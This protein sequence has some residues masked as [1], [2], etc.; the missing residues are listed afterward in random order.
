MKPIA[1]L[2]SGEQVIFT[3]YTLQA[4]ANFINSLIYRSFNRFMKIHRWNQ[5][6]GPKVTR[7]RS[8]E[9]YKLKPFN[10]EKRYKR[11]YMPS[12]FGTA[13]RFEYFDEKYV[14]TEG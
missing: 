11:R 3:G 14:P 1:N 4:V 2:S 12:T 8:S 7:I 9:T 13:A 5:T 6:G 10:E